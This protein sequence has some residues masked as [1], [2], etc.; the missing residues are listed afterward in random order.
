MDRLGK[1][2]QGQKVKVVTRKGTMVYAT[3]KVVTW[4]KDRSARP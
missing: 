1:L 2:R 3:T 4:S